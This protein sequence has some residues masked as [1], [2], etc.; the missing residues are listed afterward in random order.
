MIEGRDFAAAATVGSRERQ[1][2]DWGTHVDPPALEGRAVLL[3]TVADGM[4]GMPA[5]HVASGLAVRGFL[6]SYLTIQKPAR[7]RLRIALAHAN[8]EVGIAIEDDPDLAGM[9]STL[10][11]ALFFLDRCEWLSVGDSLILL[12]RR[13]LVWRVNPLH[14][15]ARKLDARAERGEISVECALANPDRAALTSV[16]SGGPIEEVAQGELHLEPGDLAILASDGIATLSEKEVASI[17]C[18]LRAQDAKE[19]ADTL[20][21]RIE[22]YCDGSQDNATVIVVRRPADEEPTAAIRPQATRKRITGRQ[23]ESRGG[24]EE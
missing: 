7:D 12:L 8:R 21:A 6:D 13:G 4:G 23:A 5:G 2:D 11:A 9:G 19:V 14:T 3:A 16:I 20:V 24:T 1:E 10:V 22:A 15:Y 17:C 18:G